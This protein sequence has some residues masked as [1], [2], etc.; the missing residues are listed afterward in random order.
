MLC[1]P[2]PLASG[3][4]EQ[5]I[6]VAY[7]KIDVMALAFVVFQIANNMTS[8]WECL[9]KPMLSIMRTVLNFIRRMNSIYYGSEL[10]S[11]SAPI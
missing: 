6:V 8:L 5:S 7:H 3:R 11:T 4:G 9:G 1:S 10:H 2:L